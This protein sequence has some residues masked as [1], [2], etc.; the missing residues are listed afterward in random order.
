MKP[1]SLRDRI[2]VLCIGAFVIGAIAGGIVAS[3]F[4]KPVVLREV[5][6]E[7]SEGDTLWTIADRF[8]DNSVDIRNT[9]YKI[10]EFNCL[11]TSEIYPGDVIIIPLEMIGE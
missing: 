6:V 4:K 10:R 11:N 7:V 3:A 9:I 5:S 2:K 1:L 8:T